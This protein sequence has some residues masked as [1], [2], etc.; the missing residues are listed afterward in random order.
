ME[1]YQ[2]S[3]RKKNKMIVPICTQIPRSAIFS[4]VTFSIFINLPRF[5]EL[6][7]VESTITVLEEVNDTFLFRSD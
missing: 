3:V 6:R 7:P 5:F 1:M 4:I 2:E